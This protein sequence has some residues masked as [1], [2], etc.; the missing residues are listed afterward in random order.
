MHIV[1]LLPPPGAHSYRRSQRLANLAPAAPANPN[2]D[3][4]MLLEYCHRGSLHKGLCKLYEAKR[5]G[6]P[7][8]AFPDRMLWSMFQCRKLIRILL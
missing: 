1:Q 5:A 7:N 8:L 3:G 4:I 6:Q 2:V